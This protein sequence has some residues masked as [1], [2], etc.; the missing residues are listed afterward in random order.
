M[1]PREKIVTFV[2]A[3]PTKRS[4]RL[5]SPPGLNCLIAVRSTPG[6]GIWPPIRYSTRSPRVKR[7]RCLN[8]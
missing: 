6:V 4:Y 5:K 7:I 1:I 2:K 8:S 3:P